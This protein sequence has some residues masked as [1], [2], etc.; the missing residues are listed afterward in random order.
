MSDETCPFDH[1]SGTATDTPGVSPLAK[2]FWN[3]YDIDDPDLADHWD[4]VLAGLHQGCPV[5]RSDVGEGYWVIN[6]YEDVTKAAKDWKTFSS[7]S[8]FTPNRPE[9]QP[10]WYP[11]ECDPPLHSELRKVMDGHFAPRAV[12]TIEDEIRAHA[13]L[14]LD[15]F[16]GDG[17]VDV[18]KQYTNALPGYVFC[19][20]MCGMPLEDMPWLHETLSA[21]LTGPREGRAAEIVKSFEYFEAFLK[22]RSTEEPR[23]DVVDEILAL[24]LEGYDWSMRTG[25]LAQ[26]VAAG[27]A[28]TGHVMASALWHLS[29]HEED[30][31]ALIAD[32]AAYP[33]AVEEFV[34]MYAASPHN[35]RRAT[36]DTEVAG[37]KI[38]EGDF[39]VLGWGAAS[40]DPLVCPNPGTLDIKRSPNRHVAF[41]SGVHRCIGAHLARLEMRIGLQA[42]LARIP[43]Y[44]VAEGFVPQYEQNIVRSLTSLPLEF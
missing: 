14:L 10:F 20:T 1:G 30:K 42:F 3:S 12:G 34:R 17:R 40:R 36:T 4:E 33:R 21:G 13:D 31:Q 24:D 35:G 44:R 16:V 43:D 18:V 9:G 7:T 6:R 25:T 41:G 39:V 5:A 37:T 28:T 11:V 8:G 27:I 22:K 26:T 23:G 32:A 19:G 38:E 2:R 15:G 29:E